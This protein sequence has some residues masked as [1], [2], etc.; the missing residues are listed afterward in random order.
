MAA[1]MEITVAKARRCESRM[2]ID[3]TEDTPA[4]P[5]ASDSRIGMVAF[6]LIS[7]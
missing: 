4:E 5:G 3:G 6:S 2:F 7:F 1:E